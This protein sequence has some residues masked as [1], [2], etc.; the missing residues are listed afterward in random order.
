M[1]I[2]RVFPTSRS[3]RYRLD[4]ASNTILPKCLSI[5]EFEKKAILVEG[6]KEIDSDKRVLL[7]KEASNF[8]NFEKLKIKRE[9]LSFLKSSDFLFGFFE[10]LALERVFI[11]EIDIQDTYAEY[12]EHLSILRELLDNYKKLLSKERYYDKI[13]LSEL[14][15]VNDAYIKRFDKIELFLEGYL[16]RFELELF[17]KISEI[18]DFSIFFEANEYSEKMIER[19]RDLGFDVRK[20]FEYELSFSKNSIISKKAVN[21]EIANTHLFLAQNRI[22]QV[23]YIKKKI[24]DLMGL[25]ISP[26]NMVVITPDES[27]SEILR[28]LDEDTIFNFAMGLPFSR[29]SEIY[30]RVDAFYRYL[31][32]MDIQ[33]SFRLFRYFD[34]E[35]IER[36]QSFIKESSDFGAILEKFIKPEDSLDEILVLKEEIFQF[37]RLKEEF[38]N[39][40]FKELLYLFLSRLKNK[41]LDD[42]RGGKVTVMGL[43]ESRMVAYEA[44]LIVDFNEEF[45]PRRSQ[46]ELFLST[47]IRKKVKLPTKKDRENL[48]KLYYHQILKKAK[49]SAICAVDS[50]LSK[51]SMFL[52]ELN[53]KEL[54]RE[55]LSHKR[56]FGILSPSARELKRF[57]V[58]ELRLE[59]D[60]SKIDISST[61]LKTYLECKRRYYFKYIEN[62]EEFDIPTKERDDRQVG[63]F[64]H[65]VLKDIY[66]KKDFY[67]DSKDLLRDVSSLIEKERDT[68][69]AFKL[70]SDI[71]I[72]RL[73][74]FAKNEVE[75]FKRGYRVLHTEKRLFGEF[76]GF[77]IWGVIDRIDVD[78]E[79]SLSLIDYKTGKIN[80]ANSRNL[81]KSTDFQMEFYSILANQIAPVKEVGFYDLKSGVIK[82]ESFLEEK[83]KL[84]KER[85]TLLKN[86]E[87]NFTKCEELKTCRYCPYA[88]LCGRD[89]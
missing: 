22:E 53:I 43:L 78:E 39:H 18:V 40:S 73:E 5:G 25:G 67:S 61:R 24:F 33:N 44:V 59:Y 49:I 48:Q 23:A 58:E 56:L 45:V 13:L 30:K 60:F 84:L 46:K 50:D 76:E 83:T 54:K 16:S 35:E 36:L 82:Q 6:R 32:N 26:E 68:N 9:Y 8:K 86:K 20:G 51:P 66:S 14:Y 1:E 38:K 81:E 37:Q 65:S 34:S 72:E 27:F 47:N 63:I 89:E 87:Q 17:L 55:N 70:T 11:D 77:K 28:D 31:E 62:I 41:S 74:S 3:I 21:D 2:L 75:R 15:E 57:D 71:W 80:L 85:F 88:I 52:E 4:G 69:A 29:H 19:F 12:S 10:E 64:L 42:N 79:G 7:L